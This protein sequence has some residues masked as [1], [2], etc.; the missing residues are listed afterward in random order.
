ME[1]VNRLLVPLVAVSA[2]TVLL[3]GCGQG[4]GGHTQRVLKEPSVAE[5]Y[6]LV[7][8][9][10][11]STEAALDA[12]Q[13]EEVPKRARDL[14]LS[15]GTLIGAL[16]RWQEE[17]G[18]TEASMLTSYRRLSEQWRRASDLCFDLMRLAH[19]P[20]DPQAI[21][22][23]LTELKELLPQIRSTYETGVEELH[24][25]REF[26]PDP[27]KARSNA[28]RPRCTSSRVCGASGWDVPWPAR[29]LRPA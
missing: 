4:G 13:E 27:T 19:A 26:G 29:V 28:S 7:E 8:Q 17:I 2:A 25:L 23:K 11:H 12:G 16:G 3:W 14:E 24:K 5:A 20:L 9:A 21:R 6:A 22:N 18:S 1:R 10:I 15:V